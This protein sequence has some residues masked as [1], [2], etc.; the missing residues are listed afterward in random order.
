MKNSPPM[1]VVLVGDG[2]SGKTCMIESYM[3]D[4]FRNEYLP[5]VFDNHKCKVVVEGTEYQITIWDTAGQD[6]YHV[7]KPLSYNGCDIFLI[8]FTV[9]DGQQFY[10]AVHK[11]HHE[12]SKKHSSIPKIFVGTKIDMR[13]S[14]EVREGVLRVPPPTEAEIT[15]QM[16]SLDSK[17]LECSALTQEGLK[18]AFDFAIKLILKKRAEE[19]LK[20]RKKKNCTIF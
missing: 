9:T 13:D 18:G 7:L 12:L 20:G 17:Y 11:W 15:E 10:N 14:N 6:E 1:K 5:T 4:S 16:A 2:S 3:Y 19:M 8:C